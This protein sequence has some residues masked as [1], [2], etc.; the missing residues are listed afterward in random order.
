MRQRFFPR[1]VSMDKKFIVFDGP[2]GCGKSTQVALAAE[3]LGRK[4]ADVVV[5]RDPGG[6]Q[7]GEKVRALLLDPA[8]DAMS[9]RAELLLY[10][11]SR[12]ELVDKVIVPALKD[13]KI[14]LGERFQL[15][16]V[17]YQGVALGVGV[18]AVTALGA[19]ATAGV[20]PDLTVL[21]DV[22][23]ETGMRRCGKDLDRIE[24]RGLEFHRRVRKGFLAA[25]E[26]LPRVRVVDASRPVDGVTAEVRSIL[27]DVV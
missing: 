14:V 4:G 20:E 18:D 11:A 21:L 25:A 3:Y 13:G 2:D 27:D 7:V 19:F 24:Q 1:R 15:S 6:T 17:V 8:L 16:S 22:D 26:G 5:T 9:V 12:A 23:A 10:M